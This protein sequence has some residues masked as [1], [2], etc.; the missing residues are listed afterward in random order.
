MDYFAQLMDGLSGAD[1]WMFVGGDGSQAHLNRWERM[2][3]D[4]AHPD[5][6]DRCVCSHPIQENCWLW[7][8][9]LGEVEVLG[10]CC[11]K[12]FIPKPEDRLLR[13]ADCDTPHRNLKGNFCGDCRE[14]HK[15]KKCKKIHTKIN[16]YCDSCVLTMQCCIA[17][18]VMFDASG[19]VL[20]GNCS[21]ART[22]CYNFSLD[23][24][25]TCE[26][27]K[28]RWKWCA[29]C[30]MIHLSDLVCEYRASVGGAEL[31][32]KIDVKGNRYTLDRFATPVFL[33]KSKKGAVGIFMDNTYYWTAYT[34]YNGHTFEAVSAAIQTGKYKTSYRKWTPAR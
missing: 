29:E 21:R 17:C 1:D 25:L 14:K 9:K 15:C 8:K 6:T 30:A 20:C 33:I 26:G 12:R 22:C 18:D 24:D 10:N 2:F 13:C 3:G 34:L 16:A 5:K 23:K 7:S 31:V 28:S 32:W 19:C 4:L 11:I 27:C